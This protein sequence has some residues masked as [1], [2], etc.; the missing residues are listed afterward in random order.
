LRNYFYDPDNLDLFKF[1]LKNGS[2]ITDWVDGNVLTPG[3]YNVTL[4]IP[5]SVNPSNPGV[6]PITVTLELLEASSETNDESLFYHLPFNGLLGTSDFTR[7]GYGVGYSGESTAINPI[8]L[9]D[10]VSLDIRLFIG[11]TSAAT[12]TSVKRVT[13]LKELNG[14]FTERGEMLKLSGD[15]ST[16]LFDLE[17]SLAKPNPVLLEVIRTSSDPSEFGVY[18]NFEDGSNNPIFIGTPVFIDWNPDLKS[19]CQDFYG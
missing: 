14:G 13:D 1:R 5:A 17:Y 15:T 10:I 3:V 11:G 4:G 2:S 9:N 18:Y 19:T 7:D 6:D 16:R 12:L 8:P